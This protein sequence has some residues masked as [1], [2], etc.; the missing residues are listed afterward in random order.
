MTRDMQLNPWR[1][2][3]W[4]FAA[5]LL[6]TPLVA[7]QFTREVQWDET[8][9]IVMGALIGSVG[10]GIEFLVRQSSNLAY[11][12]A[13]AIAM[14]TVFFTIW[15]NL[16]VGMI[17]SEG[18]PLNWLFGGVLVFAAIGA[19]VARLEPAGMARA[20]LAT[21]IAQAGAGAVG[22]FTDV[23]GAVVSMAFAAFWLLAAA[24]FAKAARD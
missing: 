11:R 9:F 15:V 1:I 6:V 16:A 21:S 22:L 7:M 3:G 2:A 12:L 8:D 20:M 14:L 5:S 19:I 23:R 10:L 24:L 17:G 4:G 13:A 18:N